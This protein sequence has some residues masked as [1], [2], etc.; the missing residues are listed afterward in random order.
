MIGS[1][2]PGIHH[3][4]QTI[5]NRFCCSQR[6]YWSID[7]CTCILPI[8]ESLAILKKRLLFTGIYKQ[9]RTTDKNVVCICTFAIVICRSIQISKSNTICVQVNVLSNRVRESDQTLIIR[10][11]HWFSSNLHCLT[12]KRTVARQVVMY[13]VGSKISNHRYR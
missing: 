4:Y 13:S 8:S 6:T 12:P 3:W 9:I 10:I 1:R 5:L 2:V 11:L 7:M